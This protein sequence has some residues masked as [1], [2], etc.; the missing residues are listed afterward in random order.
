MKT[1]YSIATTFLFLIV[2]S[3]AFAQTASNDTPCRVIEI[4]C[5]CEN[6]KKD[7]I[8]PKQ[9][10]GKTNPTDPGM[11]WSSKDIDNLLSNSPMIYCLKDDSYEKDPRK[12]ETKC[13]ATWACKDPCSISQIDKTH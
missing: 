10:V 9:K 13:A 4:H 5:K 7:F 1:V 8:I 3:P 12:D 11:C 2:A 6:P